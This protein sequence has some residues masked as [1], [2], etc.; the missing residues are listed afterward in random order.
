MRLEPPR[1]GPARAGRLDLI[2][3][4]VAELVRE[5]LAD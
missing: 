1:C 5:P 3:L 2:V 4:D